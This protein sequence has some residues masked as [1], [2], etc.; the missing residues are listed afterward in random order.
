MKK[1]LSI[2][3]VA[4]MLLSAAAL[5]ACDS[6]SDKG[7]TSGSTGSTNAP[8]NSEAT[9]T[10]PTGDDPAQ[11]TTQG[12][13]LPPIPGGTEEPSIYRPYEEIENLAAYLEAGHINL[14][15]DY[16]DDVDLGLTIYKGF[17]WRDSEDPEQAAMGN[18]SAPNIF[19]GDEKTK[20]C[21]GGGDVEYCSAVIWS[22]KEAVN[23][24]AYSIRTANDNVDWKD[25]NP[26]Q[27]RIY[28]SNV[29]PTV[30]MDEIDPETG[31][32]YFNSETVPEGWVLLDAVDALDPNAAGVS[33]MIPDENF[34]EAAIELPEAGKYQYFMILID[35]VESMF[36]MSEFT[37][38]GTVD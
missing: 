11:T 36:Q 18:E 28:A 33:S 6:S 23:V 19:D 8:S 37:L 5:T 35:W 20:W 34:Y 10:A 1:F 17:D 31:D 32:T 14:M 29:A 27:W 22:M 24:T 25:R 16:F 30:S 7:T 21:C 12:D 9:T 3:L 4:S 15:T 26:I 38:Y 13:D 2:A